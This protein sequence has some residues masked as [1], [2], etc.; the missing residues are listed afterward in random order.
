[1]LQCECHLTM[2]RTRIRRPAICCVSLMA[3]LGM[4]REQYDNDVVLG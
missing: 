3:L 2:L 1:M 4:G